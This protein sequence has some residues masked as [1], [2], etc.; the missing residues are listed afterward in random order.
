MR[1]V[2]IGIIS[3]LVSGS[4]VAEN[5][6]DSEEVT[7]EVISP[8]KSIFERVRETKDKV[9][10]T[11]YKYRVP[12]GA[13]LG[14]LAVIGAV[15]GMM[16]PIVVS[17]DSVVPSAGVNV[18]ESIIQLASMADPGVSSVGVGQTIIEKLTKEFVSHDLPLSSVVPNHS[19]HVPPSGAVMKTF[20]VDSSPFQPISPQVSAN[21]VSVSGVEES[22]SVVSFQAP[23]GRDSDT[24]SL[25]G[26]QVAPKTESNVAIPAVSVG[27]VYKWIIPDHVF[28]FMHKLVPSNYLESFVAS[29]QPTS[30]LLEVAG[31]NS[32]MSHLKNTGEL[33]ANEL[34]YLQRLVDQWLPG[35]KIAVDGASATV[36][37][38]SIIPS[39]VKDEAVSTASNVVNPVVSIDDVYKGILPNFVYKSMPRLSL[40]MNSLPSFIQPKQT[41]Q[42]VLQVSENVVPVTG[43][44][45]SASDVSNRSLF[46]MQV[47]LPREP[48]VASTAF[49]VEGAHKKSLPNFVYNVKQRFA[50]LFKIDPLSSSIQRSHTPHDVLREVHRNAVPV[51][52]V[53]KSASVA[54]FEA[55]SID[56]PDSLSRVSDSSSLLGMNVASPT[57]QNVA[58][59]AVS[60]GDVYKWIIPDHVFNFM[61]KIVPSIYMES[62]V[63]SFQ[64]TSSLLD[65]AEDKSALSHLKSTG[66][67]T[68]N[69]LAYLQRLVA[70][71]M[72]GAKTSQTAQNVVIPVV[73]AGG[74]SMRIL[75]NTVYSSAPRVSLMMNSFPTSTERTHTPLQV[76][77]SR[78]VVPVAEVAQVAKVVPVDM[79]LNVDAA[80]YSSWPRLGFFESIA[81]VPAAF[82]TE[83]VGAT[84]GSEP[85]S[86]NSL[87]KRSHKLRASNVS[88]GGHNTDLQQTGEAYSQ[89]LDDTKITDAEAPVAP[90]VVSRDMTDPPSAVLDSALTD[91]RQHVTALSHLEQTGE[92]NSDLKAFIRELDDMKMPDAKTEAAPKLNDMTGNPIA[93][94]GSPDNA[95]TDD[96]QHGT[97]LSHLEQTGELNSDFEEFLK[98]LN[99]FKMPEV[100]TLDETAISPAPATVAE[101]AAH[102]NDALSHLRDSGE[103]SPELE[104]FMMNLKM[105]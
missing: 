40:L 49:S 48:H 94:N 23:L 72:S 9:G 95:L 97:A 61:H 43:I 5:L 83:H 6:F 74:A 77:A 18:E 101:S 35:A 78:N 36:E 24:S 27:D 4:Q 17:T 21:V 46:G 11:L 86:V 62:F 69:E 19:M 7:A 76:F 79:P 91:D 39:A 55:L 28:N 50:Q 67:L 44:A 58:I 80:Q 103:L 85:K 45:E 14:T 65:V 33:T 16:S 31:E 13:G 25:P 8:K 99:E 12:I 98:Q 51:A 73:S 29:F 81:K 82:E 92:L 70:Q 93:V 26:M 20:K 96:R 15:S 53:D 88:F 3:F 66:E 22:A 47:A 60:V 71:W 68:A 59:P 104:A 57:A 38:L 105:K 42:Q 63:A 102:G 90:V 56:A 41:P 10:Q 2:S 64:P 75:P 87:F 37:R 52:N 34:V 84:V 54:S 100:K 30:S 89:S 1:F 32:A